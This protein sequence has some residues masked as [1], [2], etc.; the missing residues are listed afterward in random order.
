[1]KSL[2]NR[3]KSGYNKYNYG[4]EINPTNVTLPLG[5]SGFIRECSSHFIRTSAPHSG[6]RFSFAAP[7]RQGNVFFR[8]SCCGKRKVSQHGFPQPGGKLLW[9]QVDKKKK[10]QCRTKDLVVKK[11]RFLNTTF[12]NAVENHVEIRWIGRILRKIVHEPGFLFP[13]AAGF[14][15]KP[16]KIVDELPLCRYN[17]YRF[18][19]GVCVWW[20]F[21]LWG[22]SFGVFFFLRFFILCVLWIR[23]TALRSDLFLSNHLIKSAC[24]AHALPFYPSVTICLWIIL[25]FLRARHTQ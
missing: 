12:H 19:C 11:Q 24:Y 5:S 17:K 15:V 8:T 10:T 20:S 22:S 16:E 14:G 25:F 9:K 23:S 13:N 1:M 4:T 6:E 3:Y 18:P 21:A 7:N 2:D